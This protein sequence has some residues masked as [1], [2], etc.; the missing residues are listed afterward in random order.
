MM[1]IIDI[2]MKIRA[3]EIKR[4]V[5]FLE[6]VPLELV[7]ERYIKYVDQICKDMLEVISFFYEKHGFSREEEPVRTFALKFYSSWKINTPLFKLV[8]DR[9]A[10]TVSLIDEMVEKKDKKCYEEL[11]LRGVV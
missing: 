11:K 8:I 4:N 10:D 9:L 2:L 7:S 5:K 1:E 6:T 3:E